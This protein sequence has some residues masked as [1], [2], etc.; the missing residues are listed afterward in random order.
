MAPRPTATTRNSRRGLKKRP[1][2]R[3]GGSARPVEL[4]VLRFVAGLCERV[5]HPY[6][7]FAHGMMDPWFRERY[8]LKHLAKQIFWTLAE[9]RVLRDAQSVLFTCEEERVRA[10]GVFKGHPYK[11]RVVLFG[12]ADPA[13]DPERRR[14]VPVGVSR[15][16]GS[17][18]SPL[19]QPHSPQERLRSPFQAFAGASPGIAI[20]PRPGDR[21]TR[22]GWLGAGV[23]V[24]RT[25][26]RH[27]RARSLA[28]DAQG[29]YKVGR[30]PQRRSPDPS[31][32]SGEFRF[33]RRRSDGMLYPGAGQQ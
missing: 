26:P 6:Y 2:I 4:F 23:A 21:R 13:G 30:I 10:R 12:T 1:P 19:P 14:R 3:C 27:R 24:T 28:G 22:P 17:T 7:I 33:R 8:P 16:A 9:G 11:E 20:E 25:K 31:F 29:R 18:L 5:R 32:A 15:F